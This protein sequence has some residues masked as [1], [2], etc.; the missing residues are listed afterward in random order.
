MCGLRDDGSAWC[1]GVNEDGSLGDGTNDWSDDPVRVVGDRRWRALSTRQ[2]RGGAPSGTVCAID[3]DD[4][5]WCWGTNDRGQVGDGTRENRN[6]PIQ[7]GA[8]RRWASVSA[9]DHTCAVDD[10]GALHCWGG[11]AWGQL[12]IGTHGEDA[13]DQRADELEPVLVSEEVEWRE[14]SVGVEHTCAVAR[15]D[16]GWCWGH[17]RRGILGNGSEDDSPV[18]LRLP[19]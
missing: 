7:V 14:V 16:S 17:G 19:D 1:W 11:N 8:G 18:P 13:S 10:G 3:E 9:A 12:G 4:S 6:A 2:R 5:L 15:D